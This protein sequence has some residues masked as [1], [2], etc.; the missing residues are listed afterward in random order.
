VIANTITPGWVN[1]VPK[2]YGEPG[3]GSLK[4]DEWRLLATI[5]LPIALVI[6]WGEQTGQ[7][8][9]H[10]SQLLKHS[11]ALFQATTIV[12][13]YATH[14]GRAAAYREFMKEWLETLYICHPHTRHHQKRTICHMA[15][16]I[17]DFIL[18]FG[19][20]LW[21]WCYPIERLIG[22]LQQMNSNDKIGGN[23][24][25]SPNFTSAHKLRH[26]R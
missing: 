11:M 23:L 2:N 14:P 8:A 19:P 22:V 3:A 9:A 26:C 10:F 15:F 25:S 5:Y 1:H 24:L 21:W 13:R 20:A 17:Y 18:L 12:C 6:L 4:A 7:H 16:H